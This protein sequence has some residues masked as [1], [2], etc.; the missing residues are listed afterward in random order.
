VTKPIVNLPRL[1]ILK[2]G[3]LTVQ[4]RNSIAGYWRGTFATWKWG[5]IVF[6]FDE[7]GLGSADLPALK[8]HA[9][10][11]ATT[12]DNQVTISAGKDT[13]NGTLKDGKMSGRWTMESGVS[14]YIQL[15]KD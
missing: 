9:P 12:F 14:D 4:D 15:T 10:A 3:L 7:D 6:H 13:F 8:V 11:S 5:E 1:P 2:P